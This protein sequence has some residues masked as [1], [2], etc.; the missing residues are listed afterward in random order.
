MVPGH[1]EKLKFH[2]TTVVC[3]RH[4]GQVAMAGD[5]Q[6]TFH[7]MRIKQTARKIRRLYHDKVLAGFAGSAAD[8]FALLTRFESRLE[9]FRG[10]L[11][12]AVVEL[13]QDWRTDRVLRH[14]EAF[15]IVADARKMFLLSGGGD[16]IEP[17]DNVLAIGSGG[18]YAM[19]AARALMQFSSLSAAEIAQQAMKIAAQ[20]CVYTNEN[21]IIETLNAED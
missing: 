2:G 15:L 19:A 7:D 14:L 12:R 6:V 11:P 1:R 4:K 20:I 8:A 3:V 13:A 5:G 21:I 10:N 9:E 17:D 18:P 16:L